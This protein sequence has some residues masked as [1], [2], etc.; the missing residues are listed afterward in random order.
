MIRLASYICVSALALSAAAGPL[1]TPKPGKAPVPIR[2]RPADGSRIR[3]RIQAGQRVISLG[4][5]AGWRTVRRADSSGEVGYVRDRDVDEVDPK[6][7]AFSV[8]FIDV[9]SGDAAIVNVG[10]T[11]ILIDGGGSA[12]FLKAYLADRQ[13]LDGAVELVVATHPETDHYLGLSALLDGHHEILEYWDPGLKPDGM[14]PYDRFQKRMTAVAER[15]RIPLW[16]CGR[17]GPP[18][19][20]VLP[21]APEVAITILHSTPCP[22]GT[23]LDER[24]NQSSIVILLEIGGARFL[25]TGDITGK[26][27][28]EIA[29]VKAR[30]GERAVIDAL[31]K[32]PPVDVLKVPHHGSDTSSTLEFINAVRPRFAVISAN[33]KY[34]LPDPEVVE[35]YMK[36]ADVV[37]RTDIDRH[38]GNDH[39]VCR[40]RAGGRLNCSYE[41]VMGD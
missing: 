24:T 4:N 22:G 38:R 26:S 6:N 2:E 23:T 32:E 36:H 39:V 20:V 41:D 10:A 25:F 17:K 19:R 3:G 11:E 1:V 34:H 29:S 31:A 35:R 13:L 27:W 5:N 28:D 8:H 15:E 37:L 7:I 33:P 40:R 16:P 30:G 9:G 21:F 12:S 14:V 18:E